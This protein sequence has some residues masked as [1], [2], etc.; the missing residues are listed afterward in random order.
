MIGLYTNFLY[1]CWIVYSS[2]NGH[3]FCKKTVIKIVI[4]NWLYEN[5]KE[6][7]WVLL[8]CSPWE[9]LMN[10]ISMRRWKPVLWDFFNSHQTGRGVLVINYS[11]RR[12]EQNK[13]NWV[14]FL[15]VFFKVI[16][17]WNWDFE[18]NESDFVYGLV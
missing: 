16:Y 4:M 17:L 8:I 14:W 6:K 11:K 2:I 9:A 3:I 12:E 7:F 13:C 10:I 5:I 15:Y 18:T 1:L